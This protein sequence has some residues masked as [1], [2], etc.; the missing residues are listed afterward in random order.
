MKHQ[1]WFLFGIIS[2]LFLIVMPAAAQIVVPCPPPPECFRGPCIP[3][4]CP[5]PP[6]GVFTDPSWLNIDYHRVNVTV[7][8][9]IARTNVDMQFTNRG[10]GLAEGTFVFP[11]PQGASVDQLTMFVNGQAIEARILPAEEA[12]GIYNEIVRQYRDPAL[13]EYIG[14]SAIQ[15]N[16]FPIPPGESRRIQISYDQ[17]LEAENGLV[18]YVY[19]MTS[20]RAMRGRDIDQFSISLDVTSADEIGSV[21]SPT[22]NIALARE[23]SDTNHFRAGFETSFYLP[24]GDFS[25]YYA[26]ANDEISLNLLSYRESADEDGFFL[27]LVQPPLAVE[28][29][30]IVPKD[31]I[32]VVDQSG[33]MQGPKWEQAQ[34]AASYV[35][36]NLNSEDRFNVV[37]F[38]TGA[39]IYSERLESAEIAPQA[40]D[41]VNNLIAEG[42]TDINLALQTALEMTDPERPTTIM[43]LTDGLATEGVIETDDI[44]AN[45]EATAGENVRIFTFGIGDDVDT[46]LLDAVHQQFRG[47]GTY[48]RTEERIDEEVASLY[49]KI[50]APV[51]TDVQLDVEGA[52]V[53]LLYPAQLPDLFA[54]EQL[55]LVG[56]FRDAAENVTVTLSGTVNGETRSFI[57]EGLALPARAGGEPFIARLWATRRIGDLLNTIRLNGE[58]PE[59]VQSVVDLSVRYGIIT[60]Y[61][62]FLIEENDILTQSGREQAAADF[63]AEE[64]RGLTDNFTGS[65]AVDN[66]D[67]IAGLNNAQAPVPMAMPTMS[68]PYG[69]GGVTGGVGGQGGGASG[70]DGTITVA[71]VQNPVT[72]ING[73]TFINV[74]GVWNDTQFNPDTMETERIVFL[75]DEYFALLE[76]HPELADYFAL[77]ERVIVVLDGVAY[78]VVSE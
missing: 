54:G 63:A 44:L 45:V 20:A 60:P 70:G 73:K 77:G 58:N 39:R 8:N 69:Q 53:E 37:V 50:N 16:V 76:Q 67:N 29:T 38:S 36:E 1:K 51:L 24:E 2:V 26:L 9:Q 49:N 18:H 52:L 17:V 3:P 30:Q 23:A 41:W 4:P 5:P 42:G 74:E 13:L 31:V 55:T 21:Y 57:Y 71:P 78:E 6:G 22:H 40:A 43:F 72:N 47:A 75:S 12:R 56:R 14:S 27:L 68:A 48:V 7:E 61:T 33:S 28:E 34:Q 62:S 11:L 65:A 25:L 19:P 32:L 59:L 66:A 15:A 46:F 10:E 35:L 64:A